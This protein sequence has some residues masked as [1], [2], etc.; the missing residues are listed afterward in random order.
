MNKSA[1]VD[2]TVCVPARCDRLRGICPASEACKKN[3]LEQE[4]PF[5]APFLISSK[6]C[7]GCSHCVK[8]C[9]YGAIRIESGF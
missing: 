4:E 9:P 8:A 6:M 7:V 2:F 1:H 5:E 3:L